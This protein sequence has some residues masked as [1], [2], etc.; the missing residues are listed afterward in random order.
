MHVTELHSSRSIMGMQ[1][2]SACIIWVQCNSA[3]LHRFVYIQIRRERETKAYTCMEFSACIL[4]G[5][6]AWD[7]PHE[8]ASMAP[9]QLV[10]VNGS[11]L[12]DPQQVSSSSSMYAAGGAGGRPIQARPNDGASACRLVHPSSHACMHCSAG[13]CMQR[14]LFA[15]ISCMYMPGCRSACAL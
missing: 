13:R 12:L 8:R 1:C 15:S 6:H 14:T 5:M 2:N 7:R 4:M 11:E 9:N 10:P 3:K